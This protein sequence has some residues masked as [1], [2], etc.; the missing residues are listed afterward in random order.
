MEL[1]HECPNEDDVVVVKISGGPLD[2]EMQCFDAEPPALRW[3]TNITEK[4][5]KKFVEC[6]ELDSYGTFIRETDEDGDYIGAV[7][8]VMRL[9]YKYVGRR[10]VDEIDEDGSM[11]MKPI[12]TKK[13]KKKNK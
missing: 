12:K 2:G 7:A 9:Y 11:S 1:Q 4:D 13:K 5:G 3:C 8:P 10:E 6:Y